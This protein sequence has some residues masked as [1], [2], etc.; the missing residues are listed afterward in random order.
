MDASLR[1]GYM[2]ARSGHNSGSWALLVCNEQVGKNRMG[3]DD[4]KRIIRNR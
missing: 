2:L 3:I 1:G 4:I